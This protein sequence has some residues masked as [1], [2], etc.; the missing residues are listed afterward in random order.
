VSSAPAAA[1]DAGLLSQAELGLWYA[2][3]V[4]PSNPVFNTGQ[5]IDLRGPLNVDAFSAALTQAIEEA[6]TLGFRVVDTPDGPRRVMDPD[7][8]PGLRVVDV[9]DAAD[10]SAESLA[11]M[12][13]D[14]TSPIALDRDRLAATVLFRLGDTWWRWYLRIHHI[15]IDG[16]GT[17]L[18]VKRVRDLYRAAVTGT[19]PETAAFAPLRD[20]LNDEAAYQASPKFE[21][22]RQFWHDLYAD[23]PEPASLTPRA[24]LTAH[25][26]VTR[27]GALPPGVDTA[28]ASMAARSS[29]AWPDILVALTAAYIERHTGGGESI[30]GIAS[31]ERLGRPAA[32]VPS[33][34]LNILPARIAIDQTAEMAVWL[35]ATARRLQ[36]MRRHGRYRGEQLRRD[37]GLAGA[38]RRLHGPL[39]NVLPFDDG[40][41]W[42][43]L[44]SSVHLLGTGP[45]DDLTVTWRADG[46]GAGLRLELDANPGLYN[47]TDVEL[48]A[49]RLSSFV[50][51]AL[52]APTLADVPTMDEA[53][54]RRWTVDVNATDHPVP[55]VTLTKLIVDRMQ[56]TPDAPA[57]RF[58]G[59][60][61]TYRELDRRTA[62]LARQLVH[63]G[64]GRGDVVAVMAPRSFE[65]V[66][67]LIGVLRAGAAY[68]PVD[69]AYPAARVE[70]ILDSARPSLVLARGT[71]S[72]VPQ[73][74]VVNIDESDAT[75]V[76]DAAIDTA[77]P[78]DAAYVIFT[79]GSTGAP[80]GA[81][82][83]HR[84]IVN[85]LE[86]MRLFYG[87]TAEDRLLQKTPATF[88]VSVWEFFLAFTTGA[89]LV[90][91]PPDAHRDP[92][93]LASIIRNE[94]ITTVHF[95]PSM[96]AVFLEEPSVRGLTLRRVFCS[97]EE[98]PATLRDRFH[99][100]VHAELHNLYGPTEAAVDVTWWNASRG[101]T[102][103]PVPIGYPVWNTQMYV[104][105]AHL[106]PVPPGVTG[107]LYIA[108]VQLARGYLNRDDLT[109]ERFV[110]N[111]FGP[112][113]SRMYKTGDLARWELSG[114]LTFLGR[115]DFQVK[116]R[117]FR[118]ELGEIEA[119]LS[120]TGLLRQVA[121]VARE[122]RPGDRQLVAYVVGRTADVDVDAL[123]EGAA[124]RLADY[125]VPSAFV[126]LDELP[127]SANGKLQRSALPA[128]A[129][130]VRGADKPTPR[131]ATEADLHAIFA[132]VLGLDPADG[133]LG[134]DDD[135]FS[136]GGHSLLAAQVMARVRQRWRIDATLG[137]VFA[138]PTIARLGERID[139]IVAGGEDDATRLGDL[140]FG[141]I[142]QL[143]ATP[144]DTPPPLFC[145][146]PAGGLA[147]SYT[148][149]ARALDPPR[150][151]YGVQARG[152]DSRQSLPASLDDMAR[153][154]VEQIQQV[155]PH[156][157]YALAGWSVGGIL[158]HAIG[159]QLRRGGH[160]VVL[161]ALVDA[162]P[163]DRYRDEPPP[164][165]SIALRALLL[166]AGHD[167]AEI[168]G[169]LNR[170]DVLAFLKS[171]GHP[172][173]TL[174]DD[175]L[176]AIMRVVQHNSTLVRAHHH[177]IFDGDVLYFRAALD[178]AGTTLSPFDWR[179]YVTGALDV[180]EVSS[181]HAH[182][183]SPAS[184]SAIARVLN[185]PARPHNRRS[186]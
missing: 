73:V 47:E 48:H 41:A 148:G 184:V 123:R 76:P 168:P 164:D 150:R 13:R 34:V 134:R 104:L 45:V 40:L 44:D 86:W 24:D 60:T 131:T 160:D 77:H 163:A 169:E 10:P 29:V 132:D 166:V 144:D 93:W 92:A 61:W 119:A 139:A 111:P 33:M 108:G 90:V 68:L 35:T 71:L 173:G 116:I 162:Y 18:L 156:G 155:Q 122:D 103:D 181:M 80:K 37:L 115:S 43:G 87:F 141:P 172:L 96:L 85:R 142:I 106:R 67:A 89:T 161:L 88:D 105:D 52:N 99:E 12:Q 98:L 170:P 15:A 42:P 133:A 31:M 26:Y 186:S 101:D 30:V 51:R 110:P 81:V 185:M 109:A 159:G 179:P 79:S 107:D 175:A 138:H 19:N 100:V 140:G 21:A 154:Y 27:P 158:A 16:Y 145:I 54:S 165:D 72:V 74:P 151:V 84:A 49:A 7:A 69:P 39:I 23:R 59:T 58:E 153:D 137:M 167:P 130:A 180:H 62:S 5:Y 136:L 20:V 9:R 3:R 147:W 97:G 183:M 157:P 6:D 182:L 121:V 174:S 143:R 4:D 149:L 66:L 83:E 55:D 178:H 75:Q 14:M 63:R 36:R 53:E 70:Q 152:L 102:T 8:R 124:R 17:S 114:A 120:A 128:P 82:I 177:E 112:P 28:L 118:I 11:R 1:I 22:D 65:L 38:H 125:M 64:V 94:A 32:R 129:R 46:M 146:H 127:L 117:G 91:A 113:G 78:D 2:Q 126:V 176:S 57:L 56:A 135:F 171:T 95:V 50:A 25:H